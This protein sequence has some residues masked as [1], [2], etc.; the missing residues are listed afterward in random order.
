MEIIK[1]MTTGQGLE[2]KG[3]ETGRVAGLEEASKENCEGAMISGSSSTEENR[4][5][6]ET[7]GARRILSEDMGPM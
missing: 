3:R 4:N 6:K 1:R 2:E 7:T 5:G